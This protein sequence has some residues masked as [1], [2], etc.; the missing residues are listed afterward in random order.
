M[1]LE[2][3]NKNVCG[4]AKLAPPPSQ[5]GLMFVIGLLVHA[6]MTKLALYIA[7]EPMCVMYEH[8]SYLC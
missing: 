4:G 7:K 3:T 6:V 8:S 2:A 1:R 5:V